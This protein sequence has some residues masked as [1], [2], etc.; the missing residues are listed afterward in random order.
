[1]YC[2]R[3]FI[4]GLLAFLI[5]TPICRAIL[6]TGNALPTVGGN[7]NGAPCIFPFTYKGIKYYTCTTAGQDDRRLWCATTR[8][9]E[10]DRK[11][12]FC[13]DKA[14]YTVGGTGNGA[15]C[16][17]PFTYEGIQYYS[18][19]SAGQD[20]RRQW[21]ATTSS[22]DKWGFCR[23]Q[24]LP[25]VGGNADGALCVFPFTY[26]GIQYYACTS[27]AQDDRRLWCATS[28][29]YKD[30]KWGFCPDQALSTVGGN[31]DG[32]PC[33]FPFTYGGIQFDA[34]TEAGQ[35]DRRLWC[36]TT[37][38][39]DNDKQWGF[40]RDK[41]LPTVEGNANGSPCVFPFI[42]RG[43]YYNS[44]TAAGQD[45]R[46]L[47]CATTRNYDNDKK[48]GF[49]L[50][51]AL[52]TIG[53][54]ANGSPC[55]FPFT[56]NGTIYHS[57]TRLGESEGRLW[58]STTRNY[59]NDPK[60][61]F[62]HDRAL[63]NEDYVDVSP[64]VFP[65]T[66]RGARYDSC[67]STEQDDGRPWC[68][69]TTNYDIDLKR[70]FCPHKALPTVGGNA[71]GAPCVFPFTYG[72][73]QFDACTEAGQEDRRLWCATTS[74]YD[75]DKQW[76]FCRDKALPTVEGNANGSPCV[77][78]F[79]YRGIYYNSC[80]AAGQDDRR[81]WCATTRNY[82]NDKKW[83]FC[84]D[85]ALYTEG[86]NANGAPCVF[87]FTYGGIL[88][89][90]CTS[91]GQSDGKLWC[92]TARNYDNDPRWGFCPDHET[93]CSKPDEI[94]G[95]RVLD[96]KT[97]YKHGDKASY[98]CFEDYKLYGDRVVTCFLGSWQNTPKCVSE[99]CRPP[100]DIPNGKVR[101]PKKAAYSSGERVFYECE[102][103]YSTGEGTVD[104]ITCENT[105]WT[106]LAC[107]KNCGAPPSVTSGD[108]TEAKKTL[109]KSGSSAQYQ[110]A[111]LYKLE[112]SQT[113]TCNDG[114]W[115]K[116]P[117][118]RVPCTITEA[119]LQQNNIQHKSEENK[120]KKIYLQ[121]SDYTTF[122]CAPGYQIS[123]SDLLTVQCLD[124][125]VTYPKCLK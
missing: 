110:C 54:N 20:D 6:A 116:T 59:D 38:N 112:G 100:A 114:V 35:E 111:N 47:W 25:T 85:Q 77:F 71:D 42:Y 103:D 30:G 104:Y 89:Q 76:G 26:N 13:H 105:K 119:S 10:H 67:I 12:G 21:C 53:G 101:T 36:A 61:G 60:W 33:V 11:W 79:I 94:Q 56:Y 48:W 72:G 57:C 4:I 44:C 115:E 45:D 106:D 82:D 27:A 95:G 55:V 19:T 16:V 63:Y 91:A 73:I 14:Q 108:I 41:A 51:Q 22:Y 31:A 109:Y 49:C 64:C 3:M 1:M 97:K 40:C 84:L 8:N 29:D 23:D 34:C 93:S 87:P 43:I 86:G 125:V 75:N 81:L 124:G 102:I 9:Y 68:A 78:P 90:S 65:F 96:S 99:T 113:V 123:K 83:G 120:Y 32:A 92:A 17:F 15:P 70:R 50:D 18:C 117:V 107:R 24:V 58:C 74:N 62:C 88:Y 7:A 69:T 66:Y 28:S 121:H 122:E 5:P 80:T 39:Y 2:S 46:R 37:G 118:C 98:E 52:P